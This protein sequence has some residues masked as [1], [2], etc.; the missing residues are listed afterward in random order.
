MLIAHQLDERHDA[1]LRKTLPAGVDLVALPADDPWSL[2][3]GTEAFLAGMQMVKHLPKADEPPP[4]WPT[5]LKWIH[6]PSTGVDMMPAWML[7]TGLVTVARGAQSVAIA[8]YVFAAML[9]FE[10][11]VPEIFVTSRAAWTKRPL[12]GLAGRSLGL[13]GF[14]HIGQ[15]VARRA[16][17][18]GMEVRA[19]RRSDAPSPVEGVTLTSVRELCEKSQHIVVAAPLTSATRGILGP[20]EFAAMGEGVHLVNVSRGEMLDHD[21]FCKALEDGTLAR[22]TLDVWEVEPP[23]EGHFVYTHPR[24]RLSPHISFSGPTTPATTE[25]V[26]L[27]NVAAF[28]RGD[29]E[30]MHGR[31]DREAGY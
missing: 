2:P 15:E 27:D 4:G 19:S 3:P 8:E 20:A 13:V 21:A 17:A 10:K 25:K 7:R 14:G 30:A 9:A 28:L 31:V 1:M 22:A 29:L 26:M 24:V 6:L 5:G 18:F 12:G 16:L 11:H 23:P